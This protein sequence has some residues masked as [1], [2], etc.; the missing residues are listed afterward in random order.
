[1]G[2]AI[3]WNGAAVRTGS[4]LSDT[5]S[6]ALQSLIFVRMLVYRVDRPRKPRLRASD[7][8]LL[9]TQANAMYTLDSF[10]SP[11]ENLKTVLNRLG[12]C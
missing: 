12:C 5:L 1:M 10:R 11:T 4:V 8:Q 6:F 7:C 9:Q 2:I 3:V